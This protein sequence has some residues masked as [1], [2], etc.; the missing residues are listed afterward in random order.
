MNLLSQRVF[1]SLTV[2]E[3][4][5]TLLV[6]NLC[7]ILFF[8]TLPRLSWRGV[9]THKHVY[10]IA[11]CSMC[12]SQ[13][14][15]ICACRCLYDIRFI[16]KLNN[17]TVIVK[18]ECYHIGLVYVVQTYVSVIVF[19][20]SMLFRLCFLLRFE[21]SVNLIELLVSCFHRFIMI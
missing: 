12:L 21:M 4:N 10:N 3:I 1:I 18:L 2:Q 13:P 17:W 7:F 6:L 19:M 15:I 8:H 9:S 11:K 16:C 5:L 20:F 14:G